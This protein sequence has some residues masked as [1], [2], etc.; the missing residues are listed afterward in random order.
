MQSLAKEFRYLG[1]E[2]DDA[3]VLPH[4]ERKSVMFQ[5]LF[6]A[7]NL[8]AQVDHP[9]L[10]PTRTARETQ[11]NLSDWSESECC[12]QRLVG[13]CDPTEEIDPTDG[14]RYLFL[15]P[16]D[17]RPEGFPSE[18]IWLGADDESE[19]DPSIDFRR[20]G[21]FARACLEVA[22]MLDDPHPGNPLKIRRLTLKQ[23]A[24]RID[25]SESTAKRRKKAGSLPEPHFL[26]GTRAYWT[27]SQVKEYLKNG[28]T[29]KKA[30]GS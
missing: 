16:S 1:Q 17:S 9:K 13:Y 27:E 10:K 6:R 23:F 5:L 18:V 28:K 30:E 15:K 8:L 11:G 20:M 4:E 29:G 14:R 26:E 19:S 22:R 21:F 12:F 24:K 2:F 25:V 3:K 7:S